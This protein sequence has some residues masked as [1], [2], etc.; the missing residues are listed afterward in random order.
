MHEVHY[1]HVLSTD[2][3][4]RSEHANSVGTASEVEV[5]FSPTPV[6]SDEDDKHRRRGKLLE[7]FIS[8][9]LALVEI[10]QNSSLNFRYPVD[11]W[12]YDAV[13]LFSALQYLFLNTTC[14]W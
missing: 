4:P 8:A 11:S 3:W 5:A 9:F 10:A 2:G 13:F 12:Y 14:T 6:S 1:E 7:P